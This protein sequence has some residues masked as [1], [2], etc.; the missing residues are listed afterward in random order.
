MIFIS[1]LLPDEEMREVIARTNA[2][3]ESIEFSISENL[4]SLAG[5]IASYRERMKYIGAERLIL[6]GPFLDLNPVAFDR[7]IRRVSELRF[8]QAYQAAQE[9]G[10]EKIVY[11]SCYLPDVCFPAGWPERTADFYRNFLCKHTDIEV[12]MENVYERNWDT[13]LRTASLLGGTR[14]TGRFH[15]CFDTGHAGCYSSLPICEWAEHLRNYISHVHIHDNDGTRDAHSAVGS[16]TIPWKP[17]LR[18][19]APLEDLTWTIECNTQN[20]VLHSFQALTSL[21]QETAG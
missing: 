11:H 9:L 19:L 3:I 10:A 5:T 14:G 18:K 16:G 4:D 2:G 6:H 17:L 15:L 20:A 12:V 21:L 8:C 13:V 1:H 7:E